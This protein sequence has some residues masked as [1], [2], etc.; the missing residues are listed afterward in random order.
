M[1][2]SLLGV[3]V[4]SLAGP[5]DVVRL[6]AGPEDGPLADGYLRLSADTPYTPDRGYGWTV[7]A[8]LETRWRGGPDAL[9]GD[10]V[11][12]KK[13]AVLR[14]DLPDGVYR[15]SLVAGDLTASDHF[16]NV[17]ADGNRLIT[18]LNTK[19][20][21]FATVEHPVQVTDGA[22]RLTFGSDTRNWVLC[23]VELSPAAEASTPKVSRETIPDPYAALRES[24]QEPV[25]L[26]PLRRWKRPSFEAADYPN[27]A[28]YVRIIE[29]F[30][31]YAEAGWHVGEGGDQPHGWFGGIDSVENGMRTLGN[32]IL[33]YAWLATHP[34]YDANV[35]GVSRETVRQHAVEAIRHMTATHVTGTLTRPDGRQWGN[36]WQSAWWTARMVIGA[37]LLWEDLDEQERAAVDRVVQFEATRHLGRKPPSGVDFDTKSEENAW[38]SEVLAFAAARYPRHELADAWLEKYKEFAFNSLSVPADEQD[39]TVVDGRPVADWVTTV[40]VHPDFT[41]ENHG[42]YQFCYMAC[43]LHSLAIGDLAFRLHG[44]RTPDASLHHVRD[45]FGVIRKT[46]LDTRFAYLGG[47]DWPRYAYGLYFILPALARLQIVDGDRDARLFERE[48]VRMLETEQQRNGD[49]TFYARRFTGHVMTGWPSEWETDTY[50]N[51]AMA[52]LI[53]RQN[54]WKTPIPTDPAAYWKANVATWS[55][56]ANR[57]IVGRSERLFASFSWRMLWRG[58]AFGLFVPRGADDITEWGQDQFVGGFSVEGASAADRKI[59]STER[60]FDGGFT[61]T[62]RIAEAKGTIEHVVSFT[63]LLDEGLAVSMS[64]A[65]AAA[66]VTV[67]S[68]RGLCWYIPTDDPVRREHDLTTAQGR[69]VARMDAPRTEHEG[70]W[71]N[72]DD[73][74]GVVRVLGEAPLVAKRSDYAPRMNLLQVNC[75]DVQAPRTYRAGETIRDVMFV[76]VASDTARTRSVADAARMEDVDSEALRAVRLPGVNGDLL[77]IINP[78]GAS[79]VARP[80]GRGAVT[81]DALSAVVVRL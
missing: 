6:D 56:P 73:K 43:P 58:M 79:A 61:T 40:N 23:A 28:D 57:L 34:D 21:E 16:L 53:H 2:A 64:R 71:L 62:G 12:G 1:L 24:L 36:H 9:R 27:T 3:I 4:M 48:R 60:S 38:D 8:D 75:P 17:D 44:M 7:E 55:S 10:F 35:S 47:K 49:G 65:V 37:E 22:L 15:L 51:L 72:V 46:F 19:P 29:R 18:R 81:V 67:Q 5:R 39:E 59:E 13:P 50:A 54:G 78:T 14:I 74:L 20:R 33:A 69:T 26:P 80:Q 63:A 32:F 25:E 45:V 76:L 11:Y 70:S 41:I 30:P 66:D 52:E 42:A 77:V 31:N 68:Q